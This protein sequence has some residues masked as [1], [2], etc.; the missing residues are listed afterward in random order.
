MTRP[1]ME[2]RGTGARI[3]PHH[4]HPIPRLARDAARGVHAGR[5]NTPPPP[6]WRAF[7]HSWTRCIDMTY[8][9]SLIYPTPPP[10]QHARHLRHYGSTRTDRAGPCPTCTP[11]PPPHPTPCHGDTNRPSHLFGHFMGL[12]WDTLRSA[13]DVTH[14]HAAPPP[15][16]ELARKTPDTTPAPPPATNHL[17]V[18]GG[19]R[20]TAPLYCSPLPAA[21]AAPKV[22]IGGHVSG[23]DTNSGQVAG[24]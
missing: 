24:S 20:R 23:W 16:A 4:H 14:R 8:I 21:T 3:P 13:A 6:R 7:Y 17:A 15:A 22:P 12:L 5:T 11:P 9:P 1:A 19:W 18:A 10:P 2:R